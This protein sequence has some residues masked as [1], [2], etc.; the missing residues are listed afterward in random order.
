[1]F[2][3]THSSL[4]TASAVIASLS[5]ATYTANYLIKDNEKSVWLQAQGQ[6]KKDCQEIIRRASGSD[7]V[8][9][10]GYIRGD[11]N[12]SDTYYDRCLASKGFN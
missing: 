4:L 6:A 3:N 9:D 2:K 7:L 8:K 11:N 5:L 1:M 10:Y 12:Y